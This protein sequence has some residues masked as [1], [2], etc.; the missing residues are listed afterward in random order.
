MIVEDDGRSS[1]LSRALGTLGIAVVA[2]VTAQVLTA[3]IEGFA[4]RASALEP[5]GIETD[6][7]HRLGFPFGS[8][9]APAVLFLIV[10]IALIAVPILLGDETSSLHDR[11]A[12]IALLVVIAM[13]VVIA[14]GSL[15]AVR[16]QLYQFTSQ[17]VD[18]P[19]YARLGFGVY[20]LGAL[21]AAAVAVFGALATFNS[22]KRRR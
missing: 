18:P 14:L 9:G 8:L 13:A 10:G 1:R 12:T 4:A 17:G 5:N 11:L 3:V 7:F 19:P 22:R 6:L 2:V 16:Y 20:L 21:G 15:L